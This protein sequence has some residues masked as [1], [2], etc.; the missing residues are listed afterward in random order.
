MRKL[1]SS[2]H[3]KPPSCF[4]PATP[5]F[6]LL[7]GFI[8]GVTAKW[9]LLTRSPHEAETAAMKASVPSNSQGRPAEVAGR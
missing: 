9:F 7:F 3:R 2:V 8:G 6:A 4:A 1:V 5:L